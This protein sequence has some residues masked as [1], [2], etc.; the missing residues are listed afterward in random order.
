MEKLRNPYAK[1][2]GYFCFGCS[3]ENIQGLKMEF[4]KDGDRITSIWDPAG[5][6]QGFQNILHGGIQ[7]TL[8]DEI[9]SWVVFVQ[10][11]TA[12]VTSRLTTTFRKPVQIDHG[13]ITLHAWLSEMKRN[14]AVIEV[15]L[16]DGRE[17]LCAECIAEYYTFDSDRAKRKMNYPGREMFLDRKIDNT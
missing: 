13:E 16:F 14:I 8:M 10:L 9:A 11:G 3:P 5:H 12:G 17:V 15:Q 4:F 7:S 6:F 2:P 1:M